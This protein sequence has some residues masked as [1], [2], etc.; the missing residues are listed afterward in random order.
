MS[1]LATALFSVLDLVM[2]FPIFLGAG[3]AEA[4]ALAARAS[5][6]AD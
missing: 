1:Q 6:C 4:A 3:S 5:P 2:A